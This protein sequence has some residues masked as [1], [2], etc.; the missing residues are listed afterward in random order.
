M[1]EQKQCCSHRTKERSDK[2]YKDLI[3]RLNRVEGQVRGIKR[4]VEE[5]AYCTDILI[6]VSAVN[7]A[8]NSFNK[9]LLANHIRTCVAEDIIAGKEETIDELVATLQKLMK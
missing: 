6:Q 8:L 4:M 1:E 5:D 3:H 2:E 7:A 9:V